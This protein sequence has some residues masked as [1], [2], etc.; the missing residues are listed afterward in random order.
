[1]RQYLLAQEFTSRFVA[2]LKKKDAPGQADL[3]MKYVKTDVLA[4][5]V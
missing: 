2:Q 5:Q 3:Q 1:M 4:L